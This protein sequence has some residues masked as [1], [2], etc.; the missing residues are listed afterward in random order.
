LVRARSAGWVEP[1]GQRIG[2][3]MLALLAFLVAEAVGVNYFVAAFVG[4]IAFRAGNGAEVEEVTELPEL[5]GRV[6]AL[7]VWFV[8]GA[9]LLLDGI[10]VFDWRIALYAVLSLTVIRMVPVALS[11]IGSG[12]SGP[13]T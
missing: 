1:G 5:L 11:M 4:G 10:E 2:V 13:V 6:L 7:A 3:L 8:F 12:F 9:A